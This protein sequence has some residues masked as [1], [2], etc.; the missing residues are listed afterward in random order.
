MVFFLQHHFHVVWIG[1]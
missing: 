1:G